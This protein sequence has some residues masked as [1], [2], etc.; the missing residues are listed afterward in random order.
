VNSRLVIFDANM[1][2]ELQCFVLAVARLEMC[3]RFYLASSK[4][5]A[6]NC[7]EYE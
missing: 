6:L 2:V 7:T 4:N 3:C 1:Y 5:S